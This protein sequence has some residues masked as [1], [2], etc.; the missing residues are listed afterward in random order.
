[1]GKAAA[2][3]IMV[4]GINSD[5]TYLMQYYTR[6]SGRQVL[7]SSP[8]KEALTLAKREK[9]A[10]V[11][12]EADLAGAVGWDVLQALEAD[13]TTCHIPVVVCS[14]LDEATSELAERAT[15]YL[16]KPISYQDFLIA[17]AHIGCGNDL[18]G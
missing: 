16:Q 4:I 15:C 10:V 11:V 3:T 14:W 13:Q 2:S 7:V 6:K 12:L 1:V 5:F 9:P 8:D 18:R 17:L